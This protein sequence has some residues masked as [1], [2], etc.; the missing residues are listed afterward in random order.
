MLVRVV[1]RF[2]RAELPNGDMV[3]RGVNVEVSPEEGKKALKMGFCKATIGAAERP[4]GAPTPK[5]E[6]AT[7]NK[8]AGKE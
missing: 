6:K 1:K 2:L 3:E 8:E 4:K 5:K 7:K